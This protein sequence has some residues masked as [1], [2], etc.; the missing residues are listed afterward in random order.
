ML[1]P[2]LLQRLL[3][4]LLLLLLLLHNLPLPLHRLRQFLS[5]QQQLSP[6]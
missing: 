3:Q 4:L 2:H 1:F 5:V 6:H